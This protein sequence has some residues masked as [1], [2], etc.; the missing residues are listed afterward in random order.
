MV[1]QWRM[2]VRPG[3]A[4][5]EDVFMHMIQVGDESLA[6]LPQTETFETDAEIGVTFIYNGKSWRLAFDKSGTYGCNITV[7]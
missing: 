5:T 7:N 4:R 2:E 6:A 1:G 3:E